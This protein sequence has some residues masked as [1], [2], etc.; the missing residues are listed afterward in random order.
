MFRK[1]AQVVVP[2]Q[3][4]EEIQN[5][6]SNPIAIQIKLPE[7]GSHK[8]KMI[9]VR[10]PAKLQEK[11][12][13]TVEYDFDVLQHI[14]AYLRSEGF[15][16]DLG[17]D[18]RLP[19]GVYKRKGEHSLFVAKKDTFGVKKLRVVSNISEAKIMKDQSNIPEKRSGRIPKGSA[20]AAEVLA[21]ATD[22]G[23]DEAEELGCEEGSPVG[24]AEDIGADD[25]ASDPAISEFPSSGSSPDTPEFVNYLLKDPR[26]RSASRGE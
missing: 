6:R 5:L 7:V 21:G 17:R 23:H 18:P 20:K 2:K 22:T 11:E 26:E 15:S 14:I 16:S 12:N 9:G 13:L 3:T 4:A 24:C 1:T 19:Q 8:E 10:V 25:E